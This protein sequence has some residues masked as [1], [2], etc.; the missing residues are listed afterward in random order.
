[1]RTLIEHYSVSGPKD[2]SGIETMLS[3]GSVSDEARDMFD[4]IMQ[5]KDNANKEE[6]K[7]A[8]KELS[9]IHI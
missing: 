2:E 7:Q 5:M 9:L 6:T 1:M 8:L 4:A 3:R